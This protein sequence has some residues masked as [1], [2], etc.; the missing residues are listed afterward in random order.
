MT[1]NNGR[2]FYS[3]EAEQY[4]VTRYG[5]S[6]G[7]AFRVS[8]R[9]IV[10]RLL[11]KWAH[12]GRALDVGSGTGQMLPCLLAQA[13][14]IV[15][16]DLTPEMLKV[17]RKLYRDAPIDFAQGDALHLP[18]EDG[19]FDLVVSSRFLHLFPHDVQKLLLS[20]FVRVTKP[21]GIVVVDFYNRFPRRLLGFFIGAY[22]HLMRKRPHR[23]YYNTSRQAAQMLN[24]TG[25]TLLDEHGI[26]SYFLAPFLWLPQN[27]LSTMMM[28]RLFTNRF[29]SEQWIVVGRRD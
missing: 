4:E 20:E 24:S 11:A 10:T 9:E 19:S 22:R 17:A 2:E 6:Y 25:L 23:D 12:R 14:R 5:T 18:F 13:E 3:V 8:H 1:I 7:R 27:F 26:G 16:T 29:A 15:A 21:G 28:T